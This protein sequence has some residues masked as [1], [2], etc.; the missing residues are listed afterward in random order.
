MTKEKMK[1]KLTHLP[2][3]PDSQIHQARKRVMKSL[4]KTYNERFAKALE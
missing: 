1:S 3:M 2:R 4:M